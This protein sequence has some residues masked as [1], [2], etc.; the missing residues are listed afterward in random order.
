MRSEENVSD[1]KCNTSS[2]AAEVIWIG[3]YV[4]SGTTLMRV[5]LDGHP[6]VNCGPENMLLM[7]VLRQANTFLNNQAHS[8]T[9]VL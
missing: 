9:T 3:G 2:A 4:R 5:I 1:S 8:K 7:S 6:E